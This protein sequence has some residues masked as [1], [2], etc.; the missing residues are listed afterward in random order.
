VA[1]TCLFVFDQVGVANEID[2]KT[3]YVYDLHVR[4]TVVEM[5]TINS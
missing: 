4:I 1:S 5:N 3:I 2:T